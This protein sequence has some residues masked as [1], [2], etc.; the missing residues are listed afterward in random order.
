MAQKKVRE[1]QTDEIGEAVAFECIWAAVP[2]K[3]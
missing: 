3:P 1:A 2:G